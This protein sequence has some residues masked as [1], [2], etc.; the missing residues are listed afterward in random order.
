[1][2]YLEEE[3]VVTYTDILRLVDS[4]QLGAWRTTPAPRM[5]VGYYRLHEDATMRY[6][7]T[8]S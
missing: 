8:H 2:G 6:T 5:A 1:M 4:G 3:A 7:H